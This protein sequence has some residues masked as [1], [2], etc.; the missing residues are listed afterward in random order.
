MTKRTTKATI[1]TRNRTV[2]LNPSAALPCQANRV[3]LKGRRVAAPAIVKVVAHPPEI[4]KAGRDTRKVANGFHAVKEER[5]DPLRKD[6]GLPREDRP[7][8][9]IAIK[10]PPRAHPKDSDR[11]TEGAKTQKARAPRGTEKE[12]ENHPMDRKARARDLR[13]GRTIV[14]SVS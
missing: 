3:R 1:S 11:P 5:K 4:R 6:R 10:V 14:D 12:I 7:K 9:P 13:A 8:D 2:H